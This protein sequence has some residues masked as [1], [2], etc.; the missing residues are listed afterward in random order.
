M[1]L[2]I[3][4]A[5]LPLSG[6]LKEALRKVH[7]AFLEAL[8]VAV[9]APAP[10]KLARLVRELTGKGDAGDDPDPERAAP[11]RLT[12]EHLS[13]RAHF[14]LATDVAKLW[15][16]GTEALAVCDLLSR[17][18]ISILDLHAGLGT[19]TAGIALLLAAS[20][21]RGRM[22]ATLVHEDDS[23]TAM[24][25]SVADAL[26]RSLPFRLEVDFERGPGQDRHDLVMLFDPI[27]QGY[28]PSDSPEIARLARTLVAKR[29]KKTGALLVVDQA[30]RAVARA[31]AG[32][33]SL[34]ASA[35]HP[36]YSPCPCPGGDASCPCP[37]AARPG[38]FCFH[39]HQAFLTPLI[40]SAAARSGFDRT[41]VNYTYL[42][43]AA[44]GVRQSLPPTSEGQVAGRIISYPNRVKKG[45]TYFVCTGREVVQGFASRL[46]PDGV[47]RGGRLPHGT[48]VVLSEGRTE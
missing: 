36:V 20:G 15:L 8:A 32:A 46:L 42:L 23:L 3:Q 45:F 30:A 1:R 4:S 17:K 21:F 38:R 27:A 14:F 25:R 7:A 43:A 47:T 40:Q 39:S 31:M 11:P 6:E 12:R 37:Y 48:L 5:S 24:S 28:V 44:S 9:R 16:P 13:A 26:T 41:E 19:A 10:E 18:E 22:N 2:P 29:L 33:P 35:G 34:M